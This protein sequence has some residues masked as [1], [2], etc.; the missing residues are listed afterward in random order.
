MERKIPFNGRVI[1]VESVANVVDDLDSLE[2]RDAESSSP[3][4]SVFEYDENPGRLWVSV[5]GEVEVEMLKVSL[6]YATRYFQRPSP[7]GQCSN[8]GPV[9]TYGPGDSAESRH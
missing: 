7:T 8:I 2:F 5:D 3:L 4:I 1:E 9:Q 6:D